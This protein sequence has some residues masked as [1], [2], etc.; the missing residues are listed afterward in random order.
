MKGDDDNIG[1]GSETER[2]KTAQTG[3]NIQIAAPPFVETVI[4]AVDRP[5]GSQA[6]EIYLSCMGMTA[7]GQLDMGEG[8]DTIIP[9]RRVML[10][11]NDKTVRIHALQRFLQV[12]FL[13]KLPRS[14]IFFPGNDERIP[15]PA[16]YLVLIHQ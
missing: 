4:F 1:R 8:Q 12:R 9:G 11:H 16:D 7:Q 13:R 2:D 14:F 6:E 15:S 10:E 3:G 5:R